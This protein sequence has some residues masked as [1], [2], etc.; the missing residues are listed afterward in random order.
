MGE[1]AGSRAQ[2]AADIQKAHSA[3]DA[4]LAGEFDGRRPPPDVKLIHRGEV[5]GQKMV[6]ILARCRERIPY[7]LIERPVRIVPGYDRFD[8]H[9]S[10]L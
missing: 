7:R 10:L 5:A 2:P 1:I 9:E 6:H 8:V 4:E 3:V